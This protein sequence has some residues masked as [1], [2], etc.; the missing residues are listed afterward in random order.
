MKIIAIFLISVVMVYSQSREAEQKQFVWNLSGTTTTA[1]LSTIHEDN[2]QS[3]KDYFKTDNFILGWHWGGEKII[4]KVMK[5]SQCDLTTAWSW[6]L[7]TNYLIP[8]SYNDNTNLFVRSSWQA[9]QSSTS[10]DLY[11]H[12]KYDDQIMFTKSL[13]YSAALT[14]DEN[15]PYQLIKLENDPENN[16]F[17]FRF[18]DGGEVINDPTDNKWKLKLVKSDLIFMHYGKKQKGFMKLMKIIPKYRFM[19]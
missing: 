14:I 16:I 6:P 11:T 3:V 17:G 10:Y 4:S 9:Y 18:K 5:S 1:Y 19:I 8:D 2:P 12:C 15:D 13:C 7:E